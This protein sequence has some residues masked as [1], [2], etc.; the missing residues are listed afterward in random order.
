MRLLPAA[1]ILAAAAFPASAEIITKTSPHS[2]QETADR[3]SNAIKKVGAK[4]VARVDHAKAAASI[5][6]ELRP[7]TMIMFG[8][9]KVGTPAMQAEQLSGLDLPLRVL[10]FEN[11]DGTVTVAY[12][13]PAELSQNYGIPADAKA[14]QTMTGALGKLTDIA[15]GN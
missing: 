10:I 12:H 13:D 7:T 4:V 5:N 14:L 8:N 11:A 1:A 9:P 15:I 2:T 3:L 6:E